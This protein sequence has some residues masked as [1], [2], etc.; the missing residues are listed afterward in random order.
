MKPT[1]KFLLLNSFLVLFAGASFAEH[2]LRLWA[3]F[4][5]T[6]V[7]SLPRLVFESASTGLMSGVTIICSVRL[8]R[9]WLGR[10]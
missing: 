3:H 7:L 6:E 10:R 2:G 5:R 8:L 4:A 1:T 9:F